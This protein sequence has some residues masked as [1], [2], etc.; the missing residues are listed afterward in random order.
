MPTFNTPSSS[1]Q[2]PPIEH[3]AE[4]TSAPRAFFSRSMS[5]KTGTI[6]AVVALAF[7]LGLGAASQGGAVHE[8]ADAESQ[9][10]TLQTDII[11]V[12]TEL[13]EQSERA[14]QA[15]AQQQS[16][17]TELANA[18]DRVRELEE[19]AT[20][21]QADIASRDTRIAELEAEA[22]GRQVDTTPAAP[23][24]PAERAAP[25]AQPAHYQNCSAV[26]A[27]GAAPIRT[28][29]PGYGPHLDRD[30]DGIA[31]E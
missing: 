9:V 16:L 27:A 21:T 13:D 6:T 31:C 25:E 10:N 24:A 17:Q 7:G 30:G 15:H 19:S 3:V 8:L 12:Q 4:K 2:A 20:T 26:R 14:E 28:G 29:D 5:R 11:E 23:A 1:R 18:E 22:A